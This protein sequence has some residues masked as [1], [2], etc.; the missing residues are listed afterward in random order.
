MLGNLEKHQKEYRISYVALLVHAYNATRHNSTG[1]SPF[2]LMFVRHPKLAID[3]YSCLIS[4]QE[5]ECSCKEL[6]AS[7]LKTKH[8]DFA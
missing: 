2:F 6:Y 7:K 4:S 1:F 5:S 3:A 8:L